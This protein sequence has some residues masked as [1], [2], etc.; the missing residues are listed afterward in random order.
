MQHMKITPT[1]GRVVWFYPATNQATSGFTPPTEGEPLAA[2]IARV[3]DADAGAV[4]LAVF[5]GAGV[6]RSEPYV[7]LVQEGE[8]V[9]ADGRYA[10]WMPYQIGQA[11]KHANELTSTAEPKTGNVDA[12]E[13]AIERE[14]RA[15]GLTAPR[16]APADLD[17]NIVH[18]EFVKHV[19]L[20]GQV[21]RW[22]VLTTRNGFAVVGKPSVAVSPANDNAEI[23]EKVAVDNS[24]A[25][26]WPLMGYALKQALWEK[27]VS[28]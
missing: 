3:V 25:E 13:A 28:V 20:T 18:T 27:D 22:A 17:T 4:H 12:S 26:L 11:K 19:S 15:K 21:L 6:S 8:K 16:L 7:K 9:P 24:R 14:I 5:D 2:I 1:V 10:A 23:G